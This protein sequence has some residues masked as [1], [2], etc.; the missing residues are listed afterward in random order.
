MKTYCKKVDILDYQFISDSVFD[1]FKGDGVRPNKWGKKKFQYFLAHVNNVKRKEIKVMVGARDLIGLRKYTD[2]VAD[3]IYQKIFNL[4]EKDESLN[5]P[6]IGH[7]MLNDNLS[8]KIR[9]CC[10]MK[11]IHQVAEYVGLMALQ[12]L[13]KAKIE[14]YQCASVRGRGQVFGKKTLEKWIRRDLKSKYYVQADIVGCF[15]NISVEIIGNL[16]ERDIGKNKNLIKYIKALLTYYENG[17]LEIGT[18][19]SASLC[20]YVLS[21]VYR[22]ALTLN[23]TRRDKTVRSVKHTLFYMDDLYFSGANAKEL[24]KAVQ[25]IEVFMQKNLNLSLHDWKVEN[26]LEEP[27]DM[28]GYV[29]SFKKTTIRQRIF[30]RAKRQFIRALYWLKHNKFLSLLR[31]KKVISYYGYFKH[32]NSIKVAK[33]LKVNYIFKRAKKSMGFYSKKEVIN[34]AI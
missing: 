16:L 32:S 33:K 1:F 3:I 10:L 28:M 6:E 5:L 2:K 7:F 23:Y 27:I 17:K 18:V 8:G 25:K 34:Y 13:F 12:E 11:P 26:I 30:K 21:Y 20:N 22:Y 4:I 31:A 9:R 24:K 29:I 15:K 19:L 14:P